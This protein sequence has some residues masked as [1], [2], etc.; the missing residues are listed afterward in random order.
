MSSL[1]SRI[2]NFAG[3]RVLCVGDLMLDRYVYGEVERISPEAPI[4]VLHVK[5]EMATLG[6]AGN[7]VR[8]LAALGAHI[9]VIG[10]VGDDLAGEE[11]AREFKSLSTVEPHLIIDP[12]RP[13]IQKTRYVASA[14]QLLRADC[15][16]AKPISGE[17]E[18][19]IIGYLPEALKN[20]QTIVL[21][22]YLKGVLTPALIA[23]AIRLGTE[24]GKP[25]I[26]D[27]KGR[28]FAK[29]KGATMLT[30]NRKELAEATGSI[31]KTVEDADAAAQG[32]I[33]EIGIGSILVKLGA[34]GVCLVRKGEPPVHL[35]TKARE[36][37]DVSGAG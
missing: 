2:K 13:T 27:P 8:N 19:K 18:K 4:P 28:S 37:F 12:F 25:V 7:V 23:E 14:Q 15:E 10:V 9:D 24:A 36:V 30:P 6:G 11:I 1:V 33:A 32:L 16:D 26:V 34:D 35:Q 21:S 17:I 22:D 29:Y 3:C 20:A 5:R 31:I